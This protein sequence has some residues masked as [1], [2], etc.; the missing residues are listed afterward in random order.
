MTNYIYEGRLESARLITRKLTLED[1]AAWSEFFND[2]EATQFIPDMGMTTSYDKAKFWIEKQ[3]A[4]YAENRFGHQA[5]IHKDTNEF[6][7]QCGILTQDVNGEI[8]YE[9]G[10]HIFKKYWGQSYAPEA[11]KLFIDYAF[12]NNI[13]DR[14]VSII[15]INNVKSQRV[16][17][18][19]GLIREKQIKWHDMDVYIYKIVK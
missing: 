13:S 3:L 5:L 12:K 9:I 7:G 14:V 8:Y 16:A 6:I 11:A 18:K 19:N 17:D 15:D 10:Y 4:R 2:K 1:I